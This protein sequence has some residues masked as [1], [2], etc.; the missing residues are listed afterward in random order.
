MGRNVRAENTVWRRRRVRHSL[1]LDRGTLE[2]L[3]DL[4]PSV[5]YLRV[6][7]NNRNTDI[8]HSDEEWHCALLRV[9]GRGGWEPPNMH[10][11]PR[12]DQAYGGLSTEVGGPEHVSLPARQGGI[13]E[14][15]GNKWVLGI[16]TQYLEKKNIGQASYYTIFP[17]QC[18]IP[19]SLQRQSCGPRWIWSHRHAHP[20]HWKEHNI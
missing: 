10:L 16:R 14:T 6:L 19:W 7:M 8:S 11:V 1:T 4:V 9:I 3:G 13:L 18:Y 2:R 17:V 15:S 12:L 5:C 20:D